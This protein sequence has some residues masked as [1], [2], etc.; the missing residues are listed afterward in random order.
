MILNGWL[1]ACGPSIVP[2]EPAK[3]TSI[4]IVGGDR[5]IC[6]NDDRTPLRVAVQY[7]DGT[8]LAS[9]VGGD[10]DAQIRRGELTW[11]T[12]TGA[13]DERDGLAVPPDRSSWLDRP[14]AV[15]VAVARQPTL[16][17]AASFAPTYACGRASAAGMP[18]PNG[19]RGGAAANMQVALTYLDLP[20]AR[21]WVLAR[22]TV[23][24]VPG[25]RSYII[26][27]TTPGRFVVDA[28][29][30]NG[31]AGPDGSKGR[32]GSAGSDGSS[33]LSG[34]GCSDGER[35]HDGSRG[36][37][38]ERG[39]DGGA[40]GDGGNGG[41]ITVDYDERFPELAR[42]LTYDVGGGHGGAGGRG[43][44]GGSGG[45]GGRGGSGGSGG[46]G[47]GSDCITHSGMSGSD[48]GNGFDGSH[49]SAGRA[50]RPGRAGEVHARAG[51]VTALFG[52][53]LSRGLPIASPPVTGADQID[54]STQARV[55]STSR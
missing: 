34:T 4:Q 35:G 9:S 28:R 12:D 32:D 8:R 31:G 18:G 53:E 6:A 37:D 39:G 23:D 49:G 5:A 3:I 51:S 22:V 41:T 13:I 27:P 14:I 46:S 11:T 25:Q 55:S 36:G 7:R 42:L 16:V 38:G 48:G 33:G 20:Q 26:D 47:L 17:A 21:R 44:S 30:G 24:G 43:G 19:G 15:R 2:L 54:R 29:G 40:G 50:G 52:D 45:R 10:I 1:A